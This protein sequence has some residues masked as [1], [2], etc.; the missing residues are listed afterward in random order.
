MPNW[1]PLLVEPEQLQ[2]SLQDPNLVIVDL[3]RLPSYVTHH[4]P[5]AIHLEYAALV[6]SAPPVM[7]LLP[8]LRHLQSALQ[9]LGI[10][11]DAHVVAYDDEGGGKASR[12]LWTLDSIGH[13]G[14]SLLNGGIQAWIGSGYATETTKNSV[15]KTEYKIRQYLAHTIADKHYVLQHIDDPNVIFLDT[16]T[17]G[18]YSGKDVRAA[19]GGH[20]PGA[21][22]LEWTANIDINNAV[23][24]KPCDVIEAQLQALNITRDKTVVTYCQTHHRSSHTYMTLKIL[25]FEQIKGY[26]G[27]WVTF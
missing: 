20:I 24:L 8:D 23:R 3:S 10:H 11:P 22:H 21:I 6:K 27:A 1:L 25:G 26:P 16:R 15:A 7:G 19:R 18:E 14:L 5:A 2:S 13:P 9:A 12:L 17:A 4:I